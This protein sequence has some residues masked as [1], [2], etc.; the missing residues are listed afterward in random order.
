VGKCCP[1]PRCPPRP[2]GFV[3]VACRPICRGPRP[4]APLCAHSCVFCRDEEARGRGNLHPAPQ[5]KV[6]GHGAHP[7]APPLGARPRWGHHPGKAIATV[8]FGPC[9]GARGS[10]PRAGP[11]LATAS[12]R[13]FS[14]RAPTGLG[15]FMSV[16]AGEMVLPW[17]GPWRQAWRCRW[18]SSRDDRENEQAWYSRRFFKNR[19][20]LGER[21]PPL[22]GAGSFLHPNE[23]DHRVPG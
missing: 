10:T 12:G 20:F 22:F 8:S 17:C 3:P 4:Q 14:D 21:N 19:V 13:A 9:A 2:D 15:C 6:F 11:H 16:R 18:R 23:R 5:G 1:C 7:R